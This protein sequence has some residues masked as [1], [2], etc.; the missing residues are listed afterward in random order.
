MD[1]GP[2]EKESAMM[3]RSLP[4]QIGLLAVL[5]VLFIISLRTP[6]E[7]PIDPQPPPIHLPVWIDPNTADAME[8]SMMPSIGPQT[9]D[10]IIADREA[11]GPYR[12]L[13]D[14][15]R[16]PGIGPKTLQRLAPFIHIK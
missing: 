13:S 5:G 10:R 9:A 11:N 1:D 7:Y 3:L 2:I 12:S 14:L 16:V 15:D 6:T 4:L 8:L